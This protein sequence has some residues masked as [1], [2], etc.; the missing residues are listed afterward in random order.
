MNTSESPNRFEVETNTA[1]SG[2]S[3]LS[4][5]IGLAVS[6]VFLMAGCESALGDYQCVSDSD[7]NG[8]SSGR[9]EETLYCSSADSSCLSGRRYGEVSGPMT[10]EC[11][12]EGG[13]DLPPDEEL[14]VQETCDQQFGEA[15]LYEYCSGALDSCRF[16]V[17]LEL[18]SCDV[19]CQSLGG[20]CMSARLVDE[21]DVAPCSGPDSIGTSC[22]SIGVAG[23]CECS[24]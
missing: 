24:F 6:L 2:A 22:S 23:V 21:E 20:E 14:A 5:V 4:F 12:G 9:C 7:C 1:F 15:S 17:N 18:Q 13:D 10:E 16:G 11:V 19:I 3:P 8:E